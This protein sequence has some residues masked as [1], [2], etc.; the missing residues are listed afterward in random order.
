MD[1]GSSSRITELE[2]SSS[3]RSKPSKTSSV[4]C[5]ASPPRVNSN[6]DN[7][8]NNTG[9]PSQLITAGRASSLNKLTAN[10]PNN[11]PNSTQRN[12]TPRNSTVPR[13]DS[14]GIRR[15]R[16]RRICLGMGRRTLRGRVTGKGMGRARGDGVDEPLFG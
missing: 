9:N 1:S 15:D 6:R 14:R 11:T 13:R 7:G 10:T 3:N 5:M 12:S 4:P 16:S 8:R 2:D